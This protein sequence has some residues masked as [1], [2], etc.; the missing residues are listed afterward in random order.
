M[1]SKCT[2]TANKNPE[3]H[4]KKKKNIFQTA[5]KFM[6]S[7]PTSCCKVP[8]QSSTLVNANDPHG[9]LMPVG[10][11]STYSDAGRAAENQD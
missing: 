10:S 3:L 5:L 1:N 6:A 2:G 9:S 7:P 4:Q 11:T 8:R